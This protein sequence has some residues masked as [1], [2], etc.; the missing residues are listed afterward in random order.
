MKRALFIPVVA[1]VSSIALASPAAAQG[2][3]DG[4]PSSSP[5]SGAPSKGT[6]GTLAVS[7]GVGAGCMGYTDV[8]HRSLNFASVHGRTECPT[9]VPLV[10]SVNILR[11][12]WYGWDHLAN[13]Y[14]SGTKVRVNGNAKWYCLG[15]GTYTYRG[16]T[17]HRATV[18]GQALT[19]WTLR[20][21]RFAC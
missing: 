12:R 6:V 15:A 14:A 21:N 11:D 9:S 7:A 2:A 19:A 3:P 20:E 13:G 4:S 8:P 17:Y 5:L 18:G 1:L 16:E 10:A